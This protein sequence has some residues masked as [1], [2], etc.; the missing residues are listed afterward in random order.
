MVLKDV[1]GG[2]KREVYLHVRHELVRVPFEERV[3]GV[4]EARTVDDSVSQ[5]FEP[6][7][8][9]FRVAADEEVGGSCLEVVF[10]VEEAFE[11]TFLPPVSAVLDE[12]LFGSPAF[13]LW[14]GS[15]EVLVLLLG[16][17]EL[18]EF[19]FGSVLGCG[20]F[21]FLLKQRMGCVVIR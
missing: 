20:W 10:G 17:L 4:V 12:D 5:G 15:D 16:L 11:E 13:A 3:R 21:H 2:V 14:K 1:D 8:S 9:C 19:V 6:G 7:G 18:R